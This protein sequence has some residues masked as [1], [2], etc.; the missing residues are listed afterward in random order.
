[1]TDSRTPRE[2]PDAVI[3]QIRTFTDEGEQH[4]AAGDHA[5]ALPLYAAALGMVPAPIEDW[6]AT[7]WLATAMGD[8]HFFLKDFVSAQK[9]FALAVRS[10]G[11]FGNP[12]VHL[13]L[14]QCALELGDEARA[15]DELI[16]AYGLEG[17]D[18]FKDEPARYLEFLKTRAQ[19][20]E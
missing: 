16:R 19:G 11:G 5:G 4:V 12:F 6:E 1:M 15:A 9:C 13:R 20:I 8:A 7:T 10:P 17:R 18:I 14:G 2:L 3:S